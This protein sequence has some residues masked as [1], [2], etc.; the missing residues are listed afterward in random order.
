MFDGVH[1][2]DYKVNEI[3]VWHKKAVLDVF[4]HISPREQLYALFTVHGVDDA[5][6][7]LSAVAKS[8]ADMYLLHKSLYQSTSD[9][10]N[11]GAAVEK[12]IDET[13]DSLSQENTITTLDQIVSW[14]TFDLLK[15]ISV[16]MKK[17]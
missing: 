8:T 4:G 7:Y 15:G 11:I 2:P 6:G 13:I 10:Y 12:S 3:Y 9:P 16:Y 1:T 14:I 5:F 17:R